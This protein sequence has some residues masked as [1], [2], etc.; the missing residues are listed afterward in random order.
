MELQSP[1]G[2]E[3][4]EPLVKSNLTTPE[5]N[6]IDTKIDFNQNQIENLTIKIPF[7][8]EITCSLCLIGF[9]GFLYFIMSFFY[10]YQVTLFIIFA[11]LLALLKTLYSAL[12][13]MEINKSNNITN[14]N[15]KNILGCSKMTINGNIHFFYEYSTFFI[16]NDSNFD[17]STQNIK[18]KPARILYY[19]KDTIKNETFLDI[20]KKFEVNDYENPLFFDTAK[21]MGK[22]RE[23]SEKKFP[24]LSK[25]SDLIKFGEHFFTLYF[26]T[27]GHKDDVE[28]NSITICLYLFYSPI[29]IF[30]CSLVYTNIEKSKLIGLI[31][32]TIIIMI[33]ILVCIIFH[34]CMKCQLHDARIDFIYSKDFDRLFIGKVNYEE[35]SY[36]KTFEYQMNDIEKFYFQMCEIINEGM[37]LKVELKNKR[38][39]RIHK[40]IGIDK[41]DQEGLEFI[42][43]GK[44]NNITTK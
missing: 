15:I 19:I 38:I 28:R 42:L 35:N 41:Y 7:N 24:K 43:N 31:I 20:K 30:G 27:P 40:F 25:I 14:V 10:S 13:K 33:P 37:E 39:V 9:I 11:S 6:T 3:V 29:F 5:N 21:L 12:T 34:I 4:N 1:L 23:P 22:K 32:L 8:F 17:L 44:L 18:K 2:L 36:T 16:I 26:S